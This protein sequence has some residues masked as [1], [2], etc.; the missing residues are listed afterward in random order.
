MSSLTEDFPAFHGLTDAQQGQKNHLEVGHC[1]A[2]F[3]MMWSYDFFSFFI[4]PVIVIVVIVIVI[5]II[6]IIDQASSKMIVTVC[7]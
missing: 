2:G 7:S 6:V 3:A 5:I 4:P 1:L